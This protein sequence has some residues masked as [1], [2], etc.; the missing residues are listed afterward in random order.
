MIESQERVDIR[1][2]LFAL[3]SGRNWPLIGLEGMELSLEDIFMR[4]VGK[5]KDKE[6]GKKAR[7]GVK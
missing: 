7:K 4:L 3:L 5:E 2:P 1:K 6:V